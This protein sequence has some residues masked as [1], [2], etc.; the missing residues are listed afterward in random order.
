M[1]E[2]VSPTNIQISPLVK[3]A[4]S[5]IA[6]PLSASNAISACEEILYTLLKT[7]DESHGISH[8]FAVRDNALKVRREGGSGW[9]EKKGGKARR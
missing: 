9:G 7:R 1:S 3:P 6:A 4:P 2:I 8:A 5:A